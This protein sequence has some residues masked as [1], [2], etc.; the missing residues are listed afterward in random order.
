MKT[1]SDNILARLK[2]RSWE[3][4]PA[5][6]Y[7]LVRLEGE[8]GEP[9]WS[10]AEAARRV[11]RKLKT[12]VAE[13]TV[14]KW[15]KQQ[16]RMR[17]DAE[18]HEAVLEASVEALARQAQ[19]GLPLEDFVDGQII[20]LIARVYSQE[21]VEEASDFV[22]SLTALKR[23]VTADRDSR[24]GI[25]EYEESVAHLNETIGALRAELKRQGG[26]PD[27]LDEINQ[28]TVAAIDAVIL[29]G[30]RRAKTP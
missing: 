2:G 19:S 30:G 3:G 27:K 12:R 26:D 23:A 29:A 15:R 14:S 17:R 21:G 8:D 1:R 9:A 18:A 7:L 28:R 16:I 5:S 4:Q 22:R 10:L 13:S 11:G 25:R 6:D 24:Q 20:L